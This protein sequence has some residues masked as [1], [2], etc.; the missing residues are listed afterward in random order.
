MVTNYLSL[1]YA[2][3]T[4]SLGVNPIKDAEDCVDYGNHSGGLTQASHPFTHVCDKQGKVSGDVE[5]DVGKG[6]GGRG[7]GGRVAYRVHSGLGI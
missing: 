4:V 3:D 7:G 6:L 1:A 2:P 5:Q